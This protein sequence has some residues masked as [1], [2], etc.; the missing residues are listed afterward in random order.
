MQSNPRLCKI[1]AT[2]AY[3]IAL[4]SS[5]Q[6]F[7][8][9]LTHSEGQKGAFPAR[10]NAHS[11]LGTAS[12]SGECWPRALRLGNAGK[13]HLLEEIYMQVAILFFV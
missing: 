9:S 3:V 12:A 11:R 1:S 10:E 5:T 4:R 7:L 2:S 8:A 6:V 13:K